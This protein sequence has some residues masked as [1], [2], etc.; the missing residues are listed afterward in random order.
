M[1]G[2]DTRA[3]LLGQSGE[4]TEYRPDPDPRPA[5]LPMGIQTVPETVGEGWQRLFVRKV[6]KP[7]RYSKGLSG[8]SDGVT[9]QFRAAVGN[10]WNVMKG[11]LQLMTV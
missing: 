1:C 7:G 6:T 2:A 4:E 8:L 11:E 5:F 9:Y 10:E 3:E